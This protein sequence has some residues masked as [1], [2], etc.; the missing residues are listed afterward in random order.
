MADAG[1]VLV[2]TGNDTVQYLRIGAKRSLGRRSGHGPDRSYFCLSLESMPMRHLGPYSM[3]CCSIPSQ[4]KT[5]KKETNS[6]GDGIDLG[7]HVLPR[8]WGWRDENGSP[9]GITR[10]CPS[11][12]GG[13]LTK[14][15]CPW[16]GSAAWMPRTFGDSRPVRWGKAEGLVKDRSAWAKF[17]WRACSSCNASCRIKQAIESISIMRSCCPTVSR[18]IGRRTLRSDLASAAG[19]I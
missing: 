18:R 12:S 6:G 4:R 1:I 9:T 7:I 13:S 15:R 2:P 10:H 5:G 3:L 19:I 8:P 17:L 16:P 14:P 11:P